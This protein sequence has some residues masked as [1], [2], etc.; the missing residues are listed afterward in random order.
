MHIFDVIAL[1]IFLSGL[2]IYINT[3]HLKL[4]SSIG[5]MLLAIALSILVLALGST[6]PQLHLAEHVKAFEFEE[7]L[8]QFV[9]SVIL[10]AGALSIDLKK[11]SKQ[12]GPILV[13][14]TVG[15]LLSTTFIGTLTYYLLQAMNINLSY[16]YCLVFGALISSTDPIAIT[17]TIKRFK[18]PAELELK[19]ASEALFTGG[20]AVVLALSLVDLAEIGKG[21]GLNFWNSSVILLTDIGGGIIFGLI[22]GYLGYRILKFIDNTETQVEVLITL[23]LVMVGAFV[24]EFIG[25]SSKMSAL[26]MGLMIA[27]F[28]SSQDE[29]EGAVSPYVFKFWNLLEETMA[30]ILFVLIGL[31]MLVIPWRYDYFAAGFF[32]VNIVLLGRWISVYAPIKVMSLKRSFDSNAVAILTWGALKGGL[33]I[34]LSLSLPAFPGRDV[35]L[36][37]TYIVVVSSVLYQGFSLPILMKSAWPEQYRN[38]PENN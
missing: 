28:G 11:L 2:F 4:P 9:L 26:I 10:F 13:I 7:V 23:A 12:K 3:F 19:V 27:N 6:F 35:I 29:A 21:E 18:I 34:A 32:A 16:L 38:R 33:P 25:V 20:I 5:L 1:L 15:V 17:K 30:A 36:T 37:M 22:F 31:E 14:A 24:A 8:H